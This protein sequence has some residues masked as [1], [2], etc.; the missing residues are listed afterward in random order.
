MLATPRKY[1]H[2]GSNAPKQKKF[3]KELVRLA[4]DGSF[5]EWRGAHKRGEAS[6]FPPIAKKPIPL[7]QDD[8]DEHTLRIYKAVYAAIK[9]LN[10]NTSFKMWATGSRVLGH[11]RTKEETEAWQPNPTKRKYSDYD[12]WTDA[13]TLPNIKELGN[14]LGEK[15]DLVCYEPNKVE[16]TA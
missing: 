15:L 3:V 14:Q 12:F 2:G 4:G 9:Q 6:K 11:W 13:P 10:P 16:I 5:A 7:N 8:F 1:V